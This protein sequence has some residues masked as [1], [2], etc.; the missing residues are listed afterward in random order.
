MSRLAEVLTLQLAKTLS[1]NNA[2]SRIAL[3]LQGGVGLEA[4]LDSEH[5][6]KDDDIVKEVVR[7]TAGL[8][9]Q[10]EHKILTE[11]IN[12]NR[13]LRFR[14]L[15]PFLSA[16]TAKAL[17]VIT[18]NYDRLIEYA[19]EIAGWGV[20][21]MFYGQSIGI[22]DA[23]TSKLSFAQNLLAKPPRIAYRKRIKLL[24]PHG[25]LDW[26][27]GTRGPIRCE[28]GVGTPLI[29][30]PGTSKYRMGYDSPFDIHRAEANEQIDKAARYLVIG[31]GFN[32]DHLETH[33][34][35]QIEAG[36]PCLILTRELTSNGSHLVK[37]CPNI[38]ALTSRGADG[39]RVTTGNTILDFNGKD[40]SD[41]EVFVAQVLQP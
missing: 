17:P 37:E 14:T 9:E 5:L 35:R 36:K 21:T 26:Y 29:I 31:Y 38:L 12:G 20:D 33:L 19:A 23:K 34:T 25:S 6:T 40:L 4:A 18:T 8:I 13:S 1:T 2:W 15:L 7:A 24:K 10:E 11:V 22:L 32:D 27:M 16:D 30:T 28:R 39:F 3:Q 41:L